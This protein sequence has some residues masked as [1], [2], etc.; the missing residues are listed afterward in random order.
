MEQHRHEVRTLLVQIETELKELE[1]WRETPPSPE[2]LASTEPFCVDTLSLSEW[3][4]WLLIPRMHALLEGGHPLP[5]SC[6]I[7]AIAEESF[8]E[9]EQDCSALLEALAALDRTLTRPH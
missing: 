3:L 1:L 5:S 4:Q 9:L 7:Q 8:K 6:N 2:A